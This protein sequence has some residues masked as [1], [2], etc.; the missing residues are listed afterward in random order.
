MPIT[1]M[2]F[3]VI[4]ANSGLPPRQCGQASFLLAFGR[5]RLRPAN[6]VPVPAFYLATPQKAGTTVGAKGAASPIRGAPLPTSGP[7]HVPRVLPLQ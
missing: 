6:H 4:T 7:G 1:D 3:C 5:A 2:T